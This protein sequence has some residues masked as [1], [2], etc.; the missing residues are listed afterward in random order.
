MENL[1]AH[2]DE[3]ISRQRA[4]THAM[5][6]YRKSVSSMSSNDNNFGR[7]LSILSSNSLQPAIT[8]KDSSIVTPSKSIAWKLLPSPCVLMNPKFHLF[9]LHGF[10]HFTALNLPYQF[11]P[12][13]ML[14]VGLTQK[15]ASRVVSAM[16][17]GGLVG[18]LI[19]GFVMDHP[20]I[21]VLKAFT[22]S[23]FVVGL[24]LL[25]FQFCTYEE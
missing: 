17:L 20:K 6:M 16:A 2:F 19:C 4:S 10:F 7:R 22:A 11:L 1:A 13:Q 5:N 24:S 8:E 25:C 12:S 3:Q 15:V 9:M 23:Q 18:R 14:S 21:G